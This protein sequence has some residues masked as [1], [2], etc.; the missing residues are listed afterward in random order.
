MDMETITDASNERL[1]QW[2]F[3]KKDVSY[4]EYL[5]HKMVHNMGICSPRIYDY[6]SDEKIMKMQ[7]IPGM[8]IADM[9]GEDFKSVPKKI[10]KEIRKIVLQLYGAHIYYPDITGYNFM[11]ADKKVWVIDFGDAF[12]Q[13]TDEREYDSVQFIEE[14]ICGKNG[15]NPEYK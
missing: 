4:K 13:V 3:T 1:Q 6:N 8:S 11:Y 7:K 2:T 10:I 14:F 15:W 5:I 12:C 9:Y